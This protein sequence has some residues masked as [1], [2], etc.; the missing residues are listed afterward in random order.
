MRYGEYNRTQEFLEILTTRDMVH[1]SLRAADEGCF[2]CSGTRIDDSRAGLCYYII[3]IA[4]E[5]FALLEEGG[6]ESV[7]NT[8][9]SRDDD[10]VVVLSYLSCSLKHGR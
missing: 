2:E 6:V 9:G 7:L 4:R 10:L 1:R 8:W 5:G 3:G